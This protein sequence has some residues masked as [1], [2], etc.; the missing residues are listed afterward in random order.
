MFVVNARITIDANRRADFLEIMATFVA[1]T[2]REAG[3]SP[4]LGFDMWWEPRTS[5]PTTASRLRTK[6]LSRVFAVIENGLRP[7]GGPVRSR[8]DSRSTP[9][10]S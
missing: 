2:R 8:A 1:A 9:R 6:A 3:N 4:R 10:P 7:D 5:S